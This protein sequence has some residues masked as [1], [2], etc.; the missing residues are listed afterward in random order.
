[1]V[2]A[3]EPCK[4]VNQSLNIILRP[5]YDKSVFK[6]SCQHFHRISFW[7]S[8]APKLRGLDENWEGLLPRP[9]PRTA[10]VPSNN[11]KNRVWT[12][13]VKEYAMRMFNSKI[14]NRIEEMRSYCEFV[15]SDTMLGLSTN[16]DIFIRTIVEQ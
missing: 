2:S 4:V 9:Q 13:R 11:Q 10:P 7:L 3:K 5:A 16:T 15:H 6:K 12:S 1:M 8:S 14:F